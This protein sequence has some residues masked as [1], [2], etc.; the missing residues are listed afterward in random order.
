MSENES[1]VV[2]IVMLAHEHDVIV[3]PFGGG[4]NIAGCVEANTVCE[5]TI[6]SLDMK[7]MNN[8]KK[9]DTDSHYAVIEAGSLGPDLEEQLNALGYSLGHFPDSF[10][11]STLGGWVATRSA[12]LQS[13]V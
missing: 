12:G 10:K 8:V 7:V 11:H 13:D 5:K 9:L 3:I 2:S 1:D 6:L 4:S